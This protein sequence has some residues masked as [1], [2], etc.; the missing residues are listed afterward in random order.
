MTLLNHS[1]ARMNCQS[2]Q[3]VVSVVNKFFHS[4]VARRSFIEV[5]FLTELE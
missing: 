1:L 4:E 5:S 2:A 3:L